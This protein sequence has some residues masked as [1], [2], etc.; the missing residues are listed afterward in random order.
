MQYRILQAVVVSFWC[1]AL[2][3][4]VP[5]RRRRRS[6]RPGGDVGGC[7]RAGKAAIE[8]LMAGG[9][10]KKIE[11]EGRGRQDHLRRRGEGP[12]QER[13]VR[14]RRRRHGTL[15][16][17]ERS[18]CLAAGGGANRRRKILRL[19]RGAGRE[20]KSRRARLS[21]RSKARRAGPRSPLKLSDTGKI[22]E[23]EKE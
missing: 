17:A 10:I 5:V 13:G 23:K 14:R 18:V 9:K 4:Q 3:V 2:R 16:R 11:K 8:K 19:R 20:W 15:D 1:G 6:A 12:G 7:P 22:L 21:T